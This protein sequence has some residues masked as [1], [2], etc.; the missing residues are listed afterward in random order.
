MNHQKVT[1][2]LAQLQAELT[3]TDSERS[4]ITVFQSFVPPGTEGYVLQAKDGTFWYY[5]VMPRNW[6]P[7][8]GGQRWLYN[9]NKGHYWDTG[10]GATN[11]YRGALLA[12]LIRFLSAVS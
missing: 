3:T 10:V 6:K 11:T 5:L 1:D 7:Q 12:M 2:L 8:T 9:E 4:L